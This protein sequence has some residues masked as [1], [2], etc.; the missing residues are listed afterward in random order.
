MSGTTA[1]LFCGLLQPLVVPAA[2]EAV[3]PPLWPLQFMLVLERIEQPVR[4]TL[5]APFNV[6]DTSERGRPWSSV[7]MQELSGVPVATTELALRLSAENPIS[8]TRSEERRVG[9]E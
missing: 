3:A 4:L 9:K 2:I 1:A 6:S 7:N 5:G 8:P